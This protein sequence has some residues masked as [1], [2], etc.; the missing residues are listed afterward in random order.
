M[1]REVLRLDYANRK[2]D[3]IMG[4]SLDPQTQSKIVR[5]AAENELRKGLT[6]PSALDNAKD[7]SIL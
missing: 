1:R 7:H 5:T 3:A 6:E 4:S 2:A